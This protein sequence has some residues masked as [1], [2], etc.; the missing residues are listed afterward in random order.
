MCQVA[1]GVKALIGTTV[2]VVIDF[3]AGLYTAV[4]KQAG[5]K[6]T[7]VLRCHIEVVVAL[8]AIA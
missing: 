2:T 7:T 1:L 6:L 4:C 3:I 5:P 8:G